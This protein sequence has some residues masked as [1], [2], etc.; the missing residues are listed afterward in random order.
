MKGRG[1]TVCL[2]CNKR[3]EHILYNNQGII[4]GVKIL[5]DTDEVCYFVILLNPCK[6]VSNFLFQFNIMLKSTSICIKCAGR[7]HQLFDFNLITN[8]VEYK[9]TSGMPLKEGD[10]CKFCE[11][12]CIMTDRLTAVANEA[13]A[14]TK[15]YQVKNYS[16]HPR[17]D[18]ILLNEIKWK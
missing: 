10:I 13:I 7:M 18:N 12:D 4:F 9:R 11:G 5:Y 2:I 6:V 15:W 17:D 8:N 14:A 1:A 16:I 3:G